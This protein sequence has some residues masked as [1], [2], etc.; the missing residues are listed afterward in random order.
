MGGCQ[1]HFTV[2]SVPPPRSSGDRAE[3]PALGHPPVPMAGVRG[4]RIPAPLSRGCAV[5]LERGAGRAT[6][7][8][9]GHASGP[10]HPGG[11]TTTTTP[12]RWPSTSRPPTGT[13]ETA[14]PCTTSTPTSPTSTSRRWWRWARSA[15]TMTGRLLRWVPQGQDTPVMATPEPR[16]PGDGH[17][18]AGTAGAGAPHTSSLA[19]IRNSQLWAL[20]QGSPPSTR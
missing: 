15:R 8:Q 10:A 11:L 1:I 7:P 12:A 4:Q 6:Q 16:P 14:A 3:A 13:P 19:A 18:G 2:S 9:E 17:P 5:M 20:V